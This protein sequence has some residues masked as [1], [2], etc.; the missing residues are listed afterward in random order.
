MIMIPN[1]NAPSIMKQF[2]VILD[3]YLNNVID[4]V[5]I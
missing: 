2:R 5:E 1:G 4:V 3:Q